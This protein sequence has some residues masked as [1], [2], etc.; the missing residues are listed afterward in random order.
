VPAK[1]GSGKAQHLYDTIFHE[2]LI[3]KLPAF[4][5]SPGVHPSARKLTYLHILILPPSTPRSSIIF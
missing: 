1:M 5:A 3:Q 4:M 2:Q